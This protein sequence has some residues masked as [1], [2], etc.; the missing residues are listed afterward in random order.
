MGTWRIKSTSKN[1]GLYKN[2]ERMGSD[3]L[4]M[5]A[6]IKGLKPIGWII[7]KKT[8][9]E[10]YIKKTVDNGL[11]YSI[12]PHFW[13]THCEIGL[14]NKG[15]LADCFNF[16]NLIQTYSLFSE[17]LGY[18]IITEQD[19]EWLNNMFKLQLSDF[20]C[21]FDYSSSSKH[22]CENILT[23]LLLG[24]PIESTVAFMDYKVS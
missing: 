19:K 24:Y 8:E 22:D 2:G 20:I 15:T 3:D 16:Y 11:K 4:L 7:V 10:K 17:A 18:D 6:L 21:G 12:N 13:N 14:A 1:R 23:G 9:A 5:D